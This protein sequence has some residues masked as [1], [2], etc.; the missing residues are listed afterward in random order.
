MANSAR[1]FTEVT[2]PAGP[3]G[4]PGPGDTTGAASSTDNALVRFD[5]TTGK[6]IQ[7]STVT[8]DDTGAMTFPEMAAPSTPASGKVAVYAKAD[9]KLYIKD[10]AGAETDLAQAGGG[11]GTF[12]G[13]LAYHNA[14]QTIPNGAWTDVAF[15]SE[16][17]DTDAYH[18]NATNNERVTAPADGYYEIVGQISFEANGSGYRGA[19]LHKNG[20]SYERSVTQNPVSGDS[21]YLAPVIWEGHLTAGDYFTLRV[22]QTVGG[23]LQTPAGTARAAW[24]KIRRLG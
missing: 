11:G 21:T 8:L 3:Q 18:D 22:L 2:G 17:Y 24:L 19:S 4:A 6:V 1:S 15:N 13:C 14:Q 12:S 23:D 10:D 9:G 7:N 20:S 5:S 16:A